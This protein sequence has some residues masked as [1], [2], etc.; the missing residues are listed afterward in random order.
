MS[1]DTVECF[2]VR[3]AF[4]IVG[5]VTR[6]CISV[7]DLKHLNRIGKLCQ[8]PFTLNQ[9]QV[10]IRCNLPRIELPTELFWRP[11]V[12]EVIGAGF[13]RPRDENFFSLRFPRITKIHEDR[14]AQHAVTFSEY[15]C[16]ARDSIKTMGECD[17][18]PVEMA[19]LS[20]SISTIPSQGTVS[21][22][23]TYHPPE[24]NRTWLKT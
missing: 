12:V 19:L 6:P 2:D 18:V 14:L 23:A 13:D 20:V 24:L 21:T 3:L 10:A 5:T 11:A 9:S 17:P 1:D 22:K 7:A 16:L 15:Q 8:A 4:R